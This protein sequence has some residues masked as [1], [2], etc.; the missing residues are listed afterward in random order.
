MTDGGS[1]DGARYYPPPVAGRRGGRVNWL[2][3][4]S[5]FAVGLVLATFLWVQVL[6]P[7]G[8]GA[9]DAGE[10]VFLGPGEIPPE[11]EGDGTSGG[12][13]RGGG[14]RAG[15]SGGPGGVQLDGGSSDGDQAGLGEGSG[16]GNVVGVT[17]TLVKLGATVAESGLA[18]AF[19]GEVRQGMEAVRT[20]VNR[21]GG[22]HGR[23]LQVLYRDDGW[24]PSRGQTTL[25]NLVRQEGVFALAVSPSSEGLNAASKAGLFVDER[26]PVVGADGLNNTQFL[27]PWIWPVAAATTT[28]VHVI[29][30][31]AWDRCKAAAACNELRPAIVFGNT[32]RFGVEGAFAFNGAY[33]RLTGGTFTAGGQCNGGRNIPGF[34]PTG[35]SCERNS[36]YC[37][38]S[39][40]TGQYGSEISRVK[41]ACN[42]QAIG[43]GRCN[44]IL[45][46]LEP[47]TALQ[48]IPFF[49]PATEFEQDGCCGMAGAQP[50]FTRGLARDCGDN[51]NRMMVW[52]GY[53]P[54]IGR[55]ANEPAVAQYVQELDS[56]SQGQA[57]RFNQ[58]TLGGYIGMSLLVQALEETG[59]DLTRDGLTATLNSMA[60]KTGLT[61]PD[62]LRWTAGS[63]YANHSAQS[64]RIDYRGGQF[65]QFAP[66]AN[67]TR[68]PWL[69]QD[70]RPPE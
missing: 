26:V 1:M 7:D 38:I 29:M 9:G 55:Y 35:T 15:Q 17:N 58:F 34:S 43:G 69:G 52:T 46:L 40:E 3:A 63:R 18:K 53:N 12:A 31:D 65:N 57:D 32:Y 24:V 33:C 13:R 10:L 19:L 5:G 4:F 28:Q 56:T 67:Y 64:F 11:L 30:K 14:G 41:E 2:S 6:P 48:W 51:C 47:T 39:A 60:F 25:T 42:S 45:I 22:V 68:D 66:E 21:A 44:L 50:L 36:R 23:Q 37:G 70:N 54:P 49:Q 61:N 20:R 62:G 8:S 59:R 27:D 16:P